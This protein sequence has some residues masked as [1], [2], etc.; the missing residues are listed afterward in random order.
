MVDVDD[1]GEE[2]DWAVDGGVVGLG[3]VGFGDVEGFV[4]GGDLELV[5][6]GTCGVGEDADTVVEGGGLVMSG[7]GVRE[8]WGWGNGG[9]GMGDGR[10][11]MGDGGRT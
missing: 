5:G 1:G 10:R 7:L 6:V 3:V 11:G 8:G 4:G 2:R 9:P